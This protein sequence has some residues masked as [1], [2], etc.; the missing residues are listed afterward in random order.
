MWPMDR[1]LILATTQGVVI[2][3]REAGQ[4]VE[5]HRGLVDRQVT[6]VVAYQGVI[7]T[8]TE[9]GIFRSDD[10]GQSWREASSGLVNRHLRWMAF[11]PDYPD[12]LYA[13]T[14]PASIYQS[15]DGGE[16]WQECPEV[17]ELRQRYGW[18]LPYSPEAGCVR[19]FAFH[20]SRAYAAVE[21]GGVLVSENSGENWV[22]AGGSRGDLD[23]NIAEPFIHPDVHSIAVHPSS[24]DLVFAPTGGG[25]Y[26]SLDGGDTW[27]LLYRCYCRA[28]WIDPA[29]AEH[30][31]LGPADGVDRGGRIEESDDGGRSWTPA[32]SGLG[33][34][35]RNAMVE[36]FIQVGGNLLAVLSNGKIFATPLES[37]AWGQTLADMGR[38]NA[39]AWLAR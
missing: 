32:A 18:F 2:C 9:D 34:P 16:H 14:E 38:V 3:E 30:I 4:W 23:L 19:G 27:K 20:R 29:D 12:R 24:P 22:L 37:L 13:G 35:W 10:F 21:V 25:F 26:R 33:I 36:R 7:M 6:C 11:H 28:A 31:L 5:M 15:S 1:K 8:G 17:G 39:L